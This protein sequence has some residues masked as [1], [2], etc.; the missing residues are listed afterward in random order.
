VRSRYALVVAVVALAACTRAQAPQASGTQIRE[1]AD[2]LPTLS[3]QDLAGNPISSDDF[4]GHVLVV[5]AWASWCIPYCAQE[6]PDLVA[7]AERYRDQGVRFLGIDHMDQQ[8]A[9][10]EWVRHYGVPYPS[11][12]DPSGRVAGLLGYYGLPDT[13]VVDPSG[14][15]RYVIGPG[16][17]TPEELTSAIDRVLAQT[18]A[19]SAT[20]T[21]SPAR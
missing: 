5:N 11:L 2:P 6:Q 7:A 16:P 10:Q 12:S 8:A 17:A 4:R 21:N 14:T 13:Y 3:G 1:V 18:S 20:A 9:A 19:S 15:I